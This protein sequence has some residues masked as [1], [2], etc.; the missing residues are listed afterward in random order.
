MWI[1]LDSRAHIFQQWLTPLFFILEIIIL[2]QRPALCAAWLAYMWDA[3]SKF[4]LFMLL[5]SWVFCWKLLDYGC[6]NQ[7]LGS[8]CASLQVKFTY[9]AYMSYEAVDT[10]SGCWKLFTHYC[11]QSVNG[12][13]FTYFIFSMNW[14]LFFSCAVHDWLPF[15][16]LRVC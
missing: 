8:C 7:L 15:T 2:C 4:D 3:S 5:S 1:E 6:G 16:N 9:I 14:V 11:S 10:R 13:F 12:P